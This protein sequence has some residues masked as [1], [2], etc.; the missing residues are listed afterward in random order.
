M[1]SCCTF[2]VAV[3]KKNIDFNDRLPVKKSDD[4]MTVPKSKMVRQ[5]RLKESSVM[6]KN[7]KSMAFLRIL[8]VIF[9][10]TVSWILLQYFVQPLLGSNE[11]FIDEEFHIPQARHYCQA[12]FSKVSQFLYLPCIHFFALIVKLY[13]HDLIVL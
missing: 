12:A 5:N 10:S 2:M 8:P 6:D 4:S 3:D 7:G 9:L 1:F 11:Y 13:L